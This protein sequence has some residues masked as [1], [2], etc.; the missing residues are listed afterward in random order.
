MPL[1]IQAIAMAFGA[2]Q[3]IPQDAVERMY[4]NKYRDEFIQEYWRYLIREAR[5][6]GYA[7]DMPAAD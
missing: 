4:A 5:R 7:D 2:L 6:Q 1:N 3:P